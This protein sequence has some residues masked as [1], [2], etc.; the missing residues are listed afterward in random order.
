[1][2]KIKPQDV[3]AYKF[4][5]NQCFCD[6]KDLKGFEMTYLIFFNKMHL[7]VCVCVFLRQFFANLVR[8]KGNY[9]RH[10]RVFRKNGA[11]VATL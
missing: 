4:V 7:C 9:K 2:I 10:K 8:K 5:Y 1:M 11:Q 3:K 6:L